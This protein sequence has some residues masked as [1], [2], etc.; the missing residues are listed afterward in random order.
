MSKIFIG[1]GHG[2]IDSGA[3]ANGFQEKNLNLAI[4]LA[5]RDVLV[6]HG[7]DVKMSRVRDEN[8]TLEEEIKECNAYNPD[9][10]IDIHNNA[11]GGDGVEVFHSKADGRDDAFAQNVLNAIIEIGQN[12][13]GLKT[14]LMSNGNDWF[15]FIRQIKAPAILVECAFVDTKD[16]QIIDTAEE[17]KTMGI[18]IAKGILKTLGI[19]YKETAKQT[20]Q[21]VLYKVQV[22][23]YAE[24]KNAEAMLDKLKKAGFNGFI[25]EVG[26]AEKEVV[27]P[28]KSIDEIAREVIN[29][30][31]GNGS[32]RKKRLAE[33]G[34]DYA[35]VQAKVNELL[36]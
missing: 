15:G 6:A 30:N 17:Q 2:G 1:V 20:A 14:K 5:C 32:E 10:A 33:A 31:W 12:S 18:A 29:G 4:A 13:R 8:D 35:T 23:A 27:K 28:K 25:V 26:T 36:A 3:V 7:V 21:N 22:G 19:A 34:Y 16:V 11:G 9:Y 24:K